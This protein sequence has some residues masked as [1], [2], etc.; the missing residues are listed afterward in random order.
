MEFALAVLLF[1]ASTTVTPGPN[2]VMIMTSG[3]NHGIKKS[4]PHFMGICFGFPA[5]VVAVGLG[6]GII[7]ER[8][9]MLHEIIKVI[10]VFYLLYLAYLIAISSQN[11]LESNKSKPLTFLQA[12]IFQWVNP[13]AWIMATGAIAAYTTLNSSV[14]VQVLFI[15]LSFFV[16]AFPAVGVWL[17][18]GANLKKI[19]IKPEHQH[20]FNVSMALL[21]VISVAPIIYELA[22][23]IVT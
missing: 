22:T 16:V 10:G 18:F 13:K 11:S 3:L 1:A 23:G 6:F 19:L 21:L 4:L 17:V 2:N 9:P 14:Y 8:Y 7:F 5:M 20:R 12:A 15:A